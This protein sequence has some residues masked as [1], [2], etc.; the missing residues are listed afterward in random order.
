MPDAPYISTGKI[1]AQAALPAFLQNFTE[2]KTLRYF[3]DLR[4]KNCYTLPVLAGSTYLLRATFFY[5]NYDN[6]N[7]PPSFQLA[8]DA[9]ILTNVST[10][11]DGTYAEYH[12]MSQ[13]NI[14]YL[15]LI[16]T[17]PSSTPF[18]SGIS[19]KPAAELSASFADQYGTFLQEGIIMTTCSRVNFGGTDL[20]RYT[21]LYMSWVLALIRVIC[22]YL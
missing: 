16:R 10:S 15:C 3:D 18:I 13:G 20:I 19:L 14:T 8:I 17:S 2:M 6:A 22:D 5:G 9:T 21:N 4:L 11:S 1:Q 7:Q 12:Y